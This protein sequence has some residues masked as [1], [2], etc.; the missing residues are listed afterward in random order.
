MSLQCQH[1][2][3]PI[4]I[5]GLEIRNRIVMA[6]MG[7]NAAARDGS[8]TD[9]LITYLVA[10]ARGG[11]GL[12][13]TEDTTVGP[14]Y[15]ARTPSLADDRFVAGWRKLVG[16]VHAAGAKVGP[17]LMH[18]GFNAAPIYNDGARPVSASP[19]ASA[20][21]KVIPRELTAV[22]I[23]AIV[24]DFARAALRAW[25]AGCD[26]IQL[27][28]A[29][30]H[31]LLGAFLSPYHNKRID[32]YGGSLMGRLKLPLE[33][34]RRIRQA[35]G[36]DLP[37]LLR[38]SGDEYLP[39][40]RSLTESLFIAPLL[41]EA[42]ADGLHI[43]AG[44]SLNS[45]VS[46]PPTGSEQAPNARLAAR[47]KEVVEVP[48]IAVGR[49]SQPWAAETVLAR[50]QADMVCLG[51]ALL[52]DPEWPNKAAAGRW[53]DIA[54]CLGE[55]MCMRNLSSESHISCLINPAVCREE[56]MA[57]QP[58]G[59]SRRVLVIGGG[60]AGLEAARV[61][62]LRGHEVT[63]WEAGDKL[64]GQLRL[65]AFP[66]MKQEFVLAIQ[67][68]VRQAEMAG[69]VIQL[70][71]RVTAAEIA[72]LAPEVIILTVGGRPIIPEIPGIGRPKVV[73]AWQVLSGEVFP[74]PRVVV[75]GGG[76]VGCETADFLARVV[77]DRFPQG[78]RITIL[79]MMDEVMADDLSAY[80]SLL[81]R[82]LLDKGVEIITSAQALAV[83]EG[84]VKYVCQGQERVIGGL[85]GVVLAL[86]TRPNDELAVDLERMG[87]PFVVI[88]D[89]KKPR[90]A[91]AAIA[92]AAEA[93][94][95]I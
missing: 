87:I 25:E 13:L 34:L 80:R 41:V 76:K 72:D 9:R 58:A 84:E 50:G 93:A 53:A 81:V 7:T 51:R 37:V 82:R 59:R 49:I 66:P 83:S 17:Q 14:S 35:V 75:I 15:H 94:R 44:S 74:G 65:A 60:P 5:R 4:R 86:G 91:M 78:Q 28:C 21:L 11:V 19:I 20:L 3:R 6:P 63:L 23:E 31:H 68:L 45:W 95:L 33:V 18:P 61:A 46:V 43:S 39:G 62:A 64:G 92:E 69:V 1:L 54:P 10:R 52:A 85:N 90:N 29:H 89:A 77:N 70:N 71:H 8:I 56:E 30:V 36:P 27:H 16:A 73:T 12:I 88:G 48:V 55:T 57:L 79:E 40:G 42:G 22:E 47:I 24:E 2:F 67:Y 38:L 32:E 26:L